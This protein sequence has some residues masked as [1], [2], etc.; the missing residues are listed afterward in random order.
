VVKLKD[1][2]WNPDLDPDSKNNKRRHIIDAEPIATI[3]TTKIQP[4]EDL[5][6]GESLFH[7]QMWVKGTPLH[8]IFYS[9]SQ[10]NI[11]STF[12]FKQLDFPTTPHLQPYNIG[13]LHQGQYLCVSQQCLI[14]YDIKPLKDEVLCDV[15]PLEVYYVLLCQPYM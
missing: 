14:S 11:I 9:G 7:S 1:K 15:S 3:S 6:E 8:F 12:I 4:K 5:E 2:E 13:W 10:N